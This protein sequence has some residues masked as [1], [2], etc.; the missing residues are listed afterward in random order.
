MPRQKT[1]ASL[2]HDG[3]GPLI[4]ELKPNEKMGRITSEATGASLKC[5]V[6]GCG[7]ELNVPYAPRRIMEHELKDYFR[8]HRLHRHPE[9]RGKTLYEF[10]LSESVP[11][12]AGNEE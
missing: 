9:Y 2:P 8:D 3:R 1:Q 10:I 6:P 11:R 12:Y 4:H 7:F 5:L